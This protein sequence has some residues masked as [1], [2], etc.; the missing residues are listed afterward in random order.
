MTSFSDLEIVRSFIQAARGFLFL[1][2]V[3]MLPS[4]CRPVISP[5]ARCLETKKCDLE[6][7][8]RKILYTKKIVIIWATGLM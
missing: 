3:N 4:C 2:K 6:E 5:I 7:K 1:N 8:K